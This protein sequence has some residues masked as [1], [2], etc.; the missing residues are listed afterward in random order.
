MTVRWPMVLLDVVAPIVRRP[1]T[2]EIGTDYP[3]IATR[4]F[5]RGTFH[6]WIIHR[7]R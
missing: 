5:G 4:S 2:A 7:D 3:I 6:P 1:I